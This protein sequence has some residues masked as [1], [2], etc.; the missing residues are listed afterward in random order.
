MLFFTKLIVF[1]ALFMMILPFILFG[2]NNYITVHDN[3]DQFPPF[4]SIAKKVGLFSFD[5]STGVMDNTPAVYFGWGGFTIQ[6]F[7]YYLLPAYVAYVL[8][9]LI[10]L[11]V[12]FF[13]MYKLQ[14]ILFGKEHR[15]ILL[16]T[17]LLFAILPVI[18][19]WSISVAS[20]P[21]ACIVFYHI[22]KGGSKWWLLAALFLPFLM[23]F[24]CS[25]LFACGFW[26]AGMV[27]ASIKSKRFH[28]TLFVAFLLLCIGVVIF[29]FKLFYMQFAVGEDSESESLYYRTNQHCCWFVPLFCG[30]FLSCFYHSEIR[31]ISSL[32]YY[33][34][35]CGLAVDKKQNRYKRAI[36]LFYLWNHG[37]YL[38]IRSSSR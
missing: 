23:E 19:A 35:L 9:Y 7:A 31:G 28:S 17:S 37:V 6:N 27:I 16:F 2:E 34:L 21:L 5:V 12:G 33:V 1:G 18:P 36:C 4:W 13:S 8:T 11:L 24:H 3:L 29:N 25:A 10:S 26:L 38:F 30:G 15:E 20:I 14:C 22:Y 32:F